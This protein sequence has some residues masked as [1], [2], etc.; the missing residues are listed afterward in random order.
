MTQKHISHGKKITG[1]TYK[2]GR[3]IYL[4]IYGMYMTR[5]YSNGHLFIKIFINISIQ[6]NIF[7]QIKHMLLNVILLHH[8]K[9]QQRGSQLMLH[10]TFNYRLQE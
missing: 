3:T 5:Q 1:S 2:L 7:L 8:I 6:K 10:L 9:N 4:G